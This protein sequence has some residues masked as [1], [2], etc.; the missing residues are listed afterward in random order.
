MCTEEQIFYKI[1][2]GLHSNINLH[3]SQNYVDIN[4][5]ITYLNATMMTERV[6][7]HKDRINNLFFLHSLLI[8][9]FYKSKDLI[10]KFDIYT[11]NNNEDSNTKN[12]LGALLDNKNIE[13]YYFEGIDD[14]E[15]YKKFLRFHKVDQIN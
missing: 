15:N 1:I 12:L 11:G 6:L 9:A 7:E 4:K 14:S 8:N 5:N 10:E 13:N 3:L 2:S